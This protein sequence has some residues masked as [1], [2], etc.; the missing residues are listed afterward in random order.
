MFD[1]VEWEQGI[2]M[3]PKYNDLRLKGNSRGGQ[4]GLVR[5]EKC[6]GGVFSHGFYLL[7]IRK[8]SKLGVML[9]RLW[10]GLARKIFSGGAM[11][12]L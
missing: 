6:S 4:K 10:S 8:R 7:T 3:L 12:R 2:K 11:P 1:K 5:R 9:Y